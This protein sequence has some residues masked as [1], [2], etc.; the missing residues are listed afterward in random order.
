M[1]DPPVARLDEYLA[2]VTLAHEAIWE[3]RSAAI[4]LGLDDARG[5]RCFVRPQISSP[6]SYQDSF[7]K[8][9]A[10]GPRGAIRRFSIQPPRP[11]QR[12][13]SA[14][15]H[16]S[17]ML[18]LRACQNEIARELRRLLDRSE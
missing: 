6:A 4:V 9:G 2:A 15:R 8:P 5:D 1:A 13:C 3:L 18:G 11:R 16:K 14:D 7:V 17:A 12:D 10:Y